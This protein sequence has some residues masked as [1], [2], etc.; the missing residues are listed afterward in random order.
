MDLRGPRQALDLD[1]F[2]PPGAKLYPYPP[3]VRSTSVPQKA[4]VDTSPPRNIDVIREDLQV[5]KTGG[6]FTVAFDSLIGSGEWWKASLFQWMPREG[7]PWSDRCKLVPRLCDLFRPYFPQRR[8]LPRLIGNQEEIVFFSGT[9]TPPSCRTTAGRTGA[10]SGG[11]CQ[12]TP[13]MP[14]GC[15]GF[16]G[17]RWSC[18]GERDVPTRNSDGR[19][20]FSGLGFLWRVSCGRAPAVINVHIGVEGFEGSSINVFTDVGETVVLNWSDS[21]AFAFNDGWVHEVVNGPGHRYVLAL[22][23][24]HPDIDLHHF[25]EAFNQKT[26][27]RRWPP[28]RMSQFQAAYRRKHGRDWE[29]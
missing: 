23:W 6:H 19:P 16:L 4:D 17:V 29:K 28:K 14:S 5:L 21:K 15:P 1:I 22:G 26:V 10:C 9:R 27:V 2:G 3:P 13:C 12:E 20:R 7:S 11:P 8:A 24:M 18:C 25:A